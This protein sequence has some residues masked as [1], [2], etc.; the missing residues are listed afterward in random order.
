MFFPIFL[1]SISFSLDVITIITF[2]LPSCKIGTINTELAPFLTSFL[3]NLLPKSP[4]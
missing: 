2:I 4:L 3:D 1:I